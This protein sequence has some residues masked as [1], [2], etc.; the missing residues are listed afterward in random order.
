[1]LPFP[2]SNEFTK[3]PFFHVLKIFRVLP[4]SKTKI[5]KTFDEAKKLKQN[6]TEQ[7]MIKSDALPRNRSSDI[8]RL[9]SALDTCKNKRTENSALIDN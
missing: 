4:I 5:E 7:N 8:R 2:Y 3:R 1:M 9:F 6:R